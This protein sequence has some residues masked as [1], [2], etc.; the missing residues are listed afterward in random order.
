MMFPDD[1][2]ADG[3]LSEIENEGPMQ[4]ELPFEIQVGV[5]DAIPIEG[6]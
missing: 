4:L 5:S 1:N 2:A 6:M 3:L